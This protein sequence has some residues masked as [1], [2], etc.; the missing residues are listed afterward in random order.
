MWTRAG[1]RTLNIQVVTAVTVRGC[2]GEGEGGPGRHPGEGNVK[3]GSEEEGPGI[4]P[5]R[6]A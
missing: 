5:E 1:A 4:A 6:S 3:G 2:R